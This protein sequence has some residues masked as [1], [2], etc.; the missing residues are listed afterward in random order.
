MIY[1][2]DNPVR[3]LFH[4]PVKLFGPY[5]GPGQKAADIG[6]GLGFFTLGLARLAGPAGRIYAL[7]LQEKMLAGVRRRARRAGL[8]NRI[9]TRLVGPEGLEAGD[10]AGGLDLVLAF[11]MLHEVGDQGGFLDQV[12]RMLKPGGSLF[13]AEPRLH[14]TAKEFASSLALAGK[15]GFELH[16]EPKVKFSRAAVLRAD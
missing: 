13:V 10:L 3:R 2:F 8:E 15:A 1:T 4:D 5:L 6:C 11:W 14:V 16:R 12:K 7:D 9:E